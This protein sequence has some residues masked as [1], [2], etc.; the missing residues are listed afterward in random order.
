MGLVNLRMTI[1]PRSGRRILRIYPCLLFLPPYG[2][3]SPAPP[4]EPAPPKRAPKQ[5]KDA[6]PKGPPRLKPIQLSTECMAKGMSALL[7]LQNHMA[8]TK[9][10][11]SGQEIC[12]R[13][14]SHSGCTKCDRGHLTADNLS[15]ITLSPWLRILLINLKGY[16][17]EKMITDAQGQQRALSK[18]QQEGSA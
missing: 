8:S 18:L 3:E 15:G 2:R 5:K 10:L 6:K 4:V 16:R 1:R 9:V 11:R 7:E 12:L 14:L 17:G 13:F